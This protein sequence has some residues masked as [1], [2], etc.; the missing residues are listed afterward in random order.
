MRPSETMFLALN[1]DF[2][3]LGPGGLRMGICHS[4]N[5]CLLVLQWVD[6]GLTLSRECCCC[7]LILFWMHLFTLMVVLIPDHS[8]LVLPMFSP[9]NEHSQWDPKNSLSFLGGRF[10]LPGHLAHWPCAQALWVSPPPPRSPPFSYERKLP[11]QGLQPTPSQPSSAAQTW[12]STSHAG[13]ASI[14]SIALPTI[15]WPFWFRY[16]PLT[17][18]LSPLSVSLGCGYHWWPIS[19]SNPASPSEP[20]LNRLPESSFLKTDFKYLAFLKWTYIHCLFPTYWSPLSPL[21]S[22][23]STTPVTAFKYQIHS[24]N[25]IYILNISI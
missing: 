9:G 6:E 10:L 14:Q 4:L 19:S 8:L 22:V 2:G 23:A 1:T 11:C 12:Y 5:F 15:W 24:K 18:K 25:I 16:S 17:T 7:T 20:L 3:F 21:Q 13:C